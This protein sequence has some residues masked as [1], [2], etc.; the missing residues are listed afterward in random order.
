LADDG[1]GTL[2]A[3]LA[4]VGP[5][6]V[7][8]SVAGTIELKSRI[9]IV[10]PYVTVAGQTAPGGGITLRAAQGGGA[11]LSIRTH[12]V[13]VR[14]LRIRSGKVG[15]PAQGQVNIQIDSGAHDVIVDH[16]SL[17]WS[18]DENLNISRN[19]PAGENPA[20]WPQIFNIT[21]QRSLMAEGLLTHSTGTR[22][23][24]EFATEGWRGIHEVSLHHNLYAGNNARNPSVGAERLAIVNNVVHQW[25]SELGATTSGAVVDWIGNY[26]KPGNL[27]ALDQMLVHNAFERDSPQIRYPAPSLYMLDNI[28]PPSGARDFDL[29]A[30]HYSSEP[31]PQAFRRGMPLPRAPFPVGIESPAQAYSSVLADVGANARVDC[32]GKWVRNEDAADLRCIAGVRNNTPRAEFVSDPAEVGGYPAIPAGT[33]CSDADADGMPDQWETAHGLN[34]RA[35]DSAGTN[36][37]PVYSNI[38][39]YANGLKPIP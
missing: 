1:P 9:E 2:R 24:G 39:V 28:M 7:V 32:S 14:Y 23:G 25:G 13:V 33:P 31:L 20:S 16:C 4:A 22:V 8:F 21:V 34:P 35:D 30:I 10:E 3:A 17:S 18:L 12:D 29:Y 11:M 5:R 36:L 26:F 6:F 15:R 27:S 37:D 38:E 19:I